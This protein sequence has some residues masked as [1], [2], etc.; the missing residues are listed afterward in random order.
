MNASRSSAELVFELLG[1][2]QRGDEEKLRSLIHPEAEVHGAPGLLNAG[3]YHGYDGFR[4]WLGQWEDAWEEISY[5]PG[6]IMELDEHLAVIP[7]HTVGI[8]RSGVQV[9]SIFGWLYEWRDGLTVRFHVYPDPD[10]A[11]EA[12]R[13]IAAQ[14]S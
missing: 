10:S 4:E 6:E 14:R 12:G 1:A 3:T 8:G 13:R 11:L 7:V 9:D 2:Y 5:E